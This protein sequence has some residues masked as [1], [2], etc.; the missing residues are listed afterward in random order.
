MVISQRPSSTFWIGSDPALPSLIRPGRKVKGQPKDSRQQQGHFC[1]GVGAHSVLVGCAPEI[2][3]RNHPIRIRGSSPMFIARSL[4]SLKAQSQGLKPTSRSNLPGCRLAAKI[5]PTGCSHG[6][7]ANRT[8]SL[9]RAPVPQVSW[10]PRTGCGS[11]ASETARAC[12]RPKA[13]SPSTRDRCPFC[14]LR[15]AHR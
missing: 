4:P 11:T 14:L 1:G 5:S 13:D 2:A 12:S 15:P 10:R 3:I 8:N 7:S 9:P 6:S